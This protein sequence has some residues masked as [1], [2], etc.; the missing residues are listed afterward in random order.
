MSCHLFKFRSKV[1]VFVIIICKH[2]IQWSTSW[3]FQRRLQK[4]LGC[5]SRYFPNFS[6]FQMWFILPNIPLHAL[7]PPTKIIKVPLKGWKIIYVFTSGRVIVTVQNHTRKEVF[8][9]VEMTTAKWTSIQECSRIC[10][11]LLQDLMKRSVCQCGGGDA[12][13]QS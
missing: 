3:I 2:K 6:C 8:K 13:M 1:D 10:A 12:L 7:V 5:S 4:K 9:R 11:I